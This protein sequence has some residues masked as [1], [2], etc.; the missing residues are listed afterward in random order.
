MWSVKGQ[1]RQKWGADSAG[2]HVS[3]QSD[4]RWL[5]RAKQ[6]ERECQ[7]SDNPR[8]TPGPVPGLLL[9]FIGGPRCGTTLLRGCDFDVSRAAS[10]S[11][12]T[13]RSRSFNPASWLTPTYSTNAPGWNRSG[14]L[15]KAIVLM[16]TA[17]RL[18]YR[19]PAGNV[20][21]GSSTIVPF[22]AELGKCPIYRLSNNGLMFPYKC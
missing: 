1:I 19:V 8:P 22:E 5:L 11:P 2:C 6:R 15:I 20:L 10:L 16:Y 18:G 7:F 3:S 9:W 13:P 4:S 12:G 17:L 21:P 14:R